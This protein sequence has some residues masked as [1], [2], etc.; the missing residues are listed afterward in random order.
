[1]PNKTPGHYLSVVT[2][3]SYFN[4]MW[5]GVPVHIIKEIAKK[6][7]YLCK[8]LHIPKPNSSSFWY[9]NPVTTSSIKKGE[10]RS[11]FIDTYSKY[12]T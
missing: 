11:P 5:Y 3:T 6:Y 7:V 4:P 9:S 10:N 1:M 2:K 12:I 8:G